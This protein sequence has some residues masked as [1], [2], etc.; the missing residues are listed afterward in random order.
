MNAYFQI[1]N[2]EQKTGLRLVPATEGGKNLTVG[3]VMDYLNYYEIPADPEDIAAVLNSLQ[4]EEIIPLS[5]ERMRPVAGDMRLEI[6]ED[7]MTATG[8]FTPPSNDGAA[9]TYEDIT[10]GLRGRNV[11]Q[12]IRE[13]EIRD[14]IAHP[15][16]MEEITLAAGTPPR[17]G[18]DAYIEYFFNT[19]LKA[20][21]TVLEDGSVDFFNLNIINHC[22][23]DDLLARLHREDPGD[24]GTD[25]FGNRIKPRNVK[26]EVLRFG[27]NIRLSE[28]RLEIYSMVSGHVSLVDGRVFVTDLMEVENVDTATGNIVFK[29]NVQVNG[30][31]NSNFSIVADGN[32]EV[33]GVVEGATIKAGGNITIARGMNGMGKG[34]L[35]CG[36]NLVAKFIENSKVEAEGYVEAESIIH[37]DVIAGTEVVVNGKHGFISGGHVCASTQ[38]DAKILGSE[39]G[40]DTIVEV[41]I[42]PVVKKR[43]RELGNRIAEDTKILERAV[44]ILEAARGRIEAGVQ[45]NES[46]LENIRDLVDVVRDKKA[47]LKENREE[48][49]ELDLLLEQEKPAQILVGKVVYPGTKIVISNVSKIIKE[50]IQYC[51][52]VRS[53]GDV[54]MVSR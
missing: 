42:S 18:T 47:S 4:K 19:D 54:K 9:I 23:V 51:K 46:Q 52:F 37:S 27:K 28:D 5:G 17:H 26:R 16:Y 8:F 31:V 53:Q 39:M 41:G 24:Y 35:E 30:N 43:H 22:E 15:R 36:G 11:S 44:P 7:N 10:A 13:E 12:G 32:V 3:E 20:K 49:R 6:S 40:T 48:Y 45:L 14:F 50:S 33:R 1:V 2:E 21:P 25:I 38:I 34:V 29:G